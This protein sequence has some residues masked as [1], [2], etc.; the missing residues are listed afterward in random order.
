M[1]SAASFFKS[2]SCTLHASLL[3]GEKNWVRG[4][5]EGGSAI[6]SERTL[7]DDGK[8]CIFLRCELDVAF[9]LAS[10]REEKGLGVWGK[11]AKR[12][13]RNL[14]WRMTGSAKTL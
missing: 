1:G 5:G 10:W 7:A 2:A 12:S 11:G 4:L 8:H 6:G 14:G 3:L 9:F 13:G